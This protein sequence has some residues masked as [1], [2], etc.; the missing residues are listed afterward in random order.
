ML[1]IHIRI[2]HTHQNA[3]IHK[4]THECVDVVVLGA[5]RGSDR[6]GTMSEV[7]SVCWL[8]T[9]HTGMSS[10]VDGGCAT[11]RPPSYLGRSCPNHS[12]E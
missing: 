11:C 1:M 6:V 9:R 12:P 3:S 10:L 7:G 2:E 4:F 5:V 8:W